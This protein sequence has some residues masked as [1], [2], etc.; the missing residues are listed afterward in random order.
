MKKFKIF[1]HI[2]LRYLKDALSAHTFAKGNDT[3]R[4]QFA[5]HIHLSQ[6][7]KPSTTLDAKKHNLSVAA[8]RIECV[9]I[10]PGEVFSFWR[11]VG[12]PN[13]KHF[14]A[15]RSIVAGK[16]Q[17]ESGGGLCQASGIIYHL[18]LMA[19]LEIIE[20][21]AHSI[22]LYTEETRFCPLG[23]DA[24]VAYGYRDLRFR[25]N[26]GT[27]IRFKFR[28]LDDTY[29]CRLES[30]SP[31]PVHDITFATTILPDGN[32]KAVATDSSNGQIIS[33]DT[34]ESLRH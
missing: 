7:F 24:T 2:A 28:I 26:T 18:A 13:T 14:A 3:A 1:L 29:E 25:N 20:R 6:P 32:K 17:L 19:G 15:S 4:P 8:G 22:D 5:H 12:D 16:L 11:I 30:E 23:S 27:A 33:T 34:Y 10:K 21:F 31:I 9:T